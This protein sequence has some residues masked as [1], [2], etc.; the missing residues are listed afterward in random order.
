MIEIIK[1]SRKPRKGR[2]VHNPV[3]SVAEC[4]VLI[5]LMTICLFACK[6]KDIEPYDKRD[7]IKELLVGD[8]EVDKDKVRVEMI[9]S[10][11]ALPFKSMAE[12]AIESSIRDEV[13]GNIL[14]ITD[15]RAYCYRQ[16]MI[17][18]SNYHINTDTLFFE[19]TRL[20]GFP[21]PHILI[22]Q[23]SLRMDKMTAYLSKDEIVN[24]LIDMGETKHLDLI[25]NNVKEARCKLIFKRAEAHQYDD[26][27][28]LSE[29][30]Q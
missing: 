21:I 1:N 14:R 30:P 24:I 12:N 13:K 3:R 16:N 7:I 9:V 27:F 29:Q 18:P 23:D 6:Q 2:T 5:M 22:Y 17:Y 26:L 15:D 4:G 20:L 25:K 10:D 19:D 8:W 28:I 11:I